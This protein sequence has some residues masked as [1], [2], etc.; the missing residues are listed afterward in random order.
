MRETGNREQS[1]DYHVL[2]GEWHGRRGEKEAARSALERGVEQASASKGRAAI[3]RAR[4]ARAAALE[5]GPAASA[6]HPAVKE[7]EALGDA[8]L[9]IR[10]A[11]SLARA[12]LGRGRLADAEASARRALRVAEDC[13]W[14]AGLYR[15]H[16]LLG[17]ILEKRGDTAGA[18]A[19]YR[20]SVRRIRTLREGLEA[21]LRESFAGSPR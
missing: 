6:L 10:A 5:P 16:A 9:R 18:A 12:E 4:I 13:G 2:M 21:D 8:L 14:E 20:E 7:A 17:R 11:E 15:L 19:Q 1:S 3:L